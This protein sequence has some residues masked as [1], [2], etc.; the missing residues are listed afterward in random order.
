MTLP[1]QLLQIDYDQFQR[2][3]AITLLLKPLLMEWK[4]A[5][6]RLRILE[7]GSNHLNLLSA[8]LSPLPV[9]VVRAD[10]EA[11]FA[12]EVGPYV[13]I[14]K[15]QPLPFG[16]GAFDVVV[17]MEVLEHIPPASRQQV[18]GEWARVASKGVLITCPNGSQVTEVER[19]ADADFFARHGRQHPWLLEHEAYG[20]PAQEEVQ[21][22]CSRAGLCCQR[23]LNSPLNEWLPLLLISEQVFESGDK[24]FFARFN[25]S[26]NEHQA[27]LFV[28]EPAYRSIYACFK[29][30]DLHRHAQELWQGRPELQTAKKAVEVDDST[31]L[32]AR[33]LSR[34]LNE[35]RCHAVDARELTRLRGENAKLN[36]ELW[37]LKE[38]LMWNSPRATWQTVNVH[39]EYACQLECAI[40][41][42]IKRQVT[43]CWRVT[44]N[45]PRLEWPCRY[46]TGWHRITLIGQ[47]ISGQKAKLIPDY[48]HG[49]AEQHAIR[50]GNWQDGAGY[51]QVDAYF[52]HPVTQ[53]RL[54]PCQGQAVSGVVLDGLTVTPISPVRVAIA[55]TLRLAVDLCRF[56]RL[57][58]KAIRSRQSMKQLV[59]Q[60]ATTPRGLPAGFVNEYQLWL[61]RYRRQQLVDMLPGTQQM[62][63]ALFLLMTKDDSPEDLAVTL[64]SLL[65]QPFSDW[66]LWLTVESTLEPLL[67]RLDEVQQ[68]GNRICWMK[69]GPDRGLAGLVNECAEQTQSGWL[70]PLRAG[71][72][73]EPTALQHWHHAAQIKRDAVLMIGDVGLRDRF[74]GETESCFQPI[75]DPERLLDDSSM[76]GEAVAVY[77]PTLLQLGGLNPSYEGALWYEYLHRVIGWRLPVTQVAQLILHHLPRQPISAA[78]HKVIERIREQPVNQD[79]D[80]SYQRVKASM[81]LQDR[82]IYWSEEALSQGNN[83][84]GSSC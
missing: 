31:R 81:G 70:L 53:L 84:A 26:L 61:A 68:A 56:P 65:R 69:A 22:W 19:R 37:N 54:I 33:R 64:R 21:K 30:T 25:E 23:F 17:A 43:N 1:R 13:T 62:N 6:P 29:T 66:K 57:T 3:A 15:D 80:I 18:I 24:E 48:G 74:E 16:D 40:H 58:W 44:G 72:V 75:M 60:H 49:F 39:N 67:K 55:G 71:D 2:Y 59:M 28:E 82:G 77:I 83:G 34:F 41:Y 52:D 20:R 14:E 8:F 38:H 4:Q 47:V 73:L 42:D 79:Y 12:G 9:E 63:L 36:E 11:V 76:P 7:A 46:E 78:A 51:L 45:Q 5:Q 27:Q 32:L 35:N 10:L 50:L